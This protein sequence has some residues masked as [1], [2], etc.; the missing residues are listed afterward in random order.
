MRKFFIFLLLI[1]VFF[2][3][4]VPVFASSGG[5]IL[6]S[7]NDPLFLRSVSQSNETIT[8]NDANGFKKVMLQ[9]IG[10]YKMVITDYTYQNQSG[11][12][13]HSVNVELDY[14]WICSCIMFIVIIFC[15]FLSVAKILSRM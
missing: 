3:L 1:S 15:T 9:L 4:G 5:A 10:D 11:Y 2:V 8:A 7:N 12:T 14:S 6:M 13:T